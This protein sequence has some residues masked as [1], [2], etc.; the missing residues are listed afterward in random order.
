MPELVLL[1]TLVILCV[2]VGPDWRVPAWPA[3][4]LG[5]LWIPPG[6]GPDPRAALHAVPLHWIGLL[7]AA[8]TSSPFTPVAIALQLAFLFVV[9]ARFPP[10]ATGPP[11]AARTPGGLRTA[12][13]MALLRRRLF[14]VDDAFVAGA[15]LTLA[16]RFDAAL[17]TLLWAALAVVIF[18]L[19]AL[20]R[21]N[22]LRY[23]ALAGLAV[24]LFRMLTVDL[25]QADLGLKGAIF[26]GMG[27]LM[28]TMNALYNRFRGR[29]E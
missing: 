18:L 5:L 13:G 15:A 19:S 3:L 28:L 14:S 21:E 22:Q 24:C 2:E 26:I 7:H 9:R 17:L 25:A 12:W 1:A 20:F 23:V 27:L 11:E 4:A 16:W 8:L 6:R 10:P 29:F